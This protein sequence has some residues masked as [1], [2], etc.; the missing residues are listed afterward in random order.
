MFKFS[1][2][3]SRGQW[4][5]AIAI[6]FPLLLVSVFGLQVVKSMQQAALYSA[7]GSNNSVLFMWLSALFSALTAGLYV[8]GVSFTARRLRDAGYSRS[9]II[10]Y[11]WLIVIF[12]FFAMFVY[13]FI[14]GF[15]PSKL[16]AEDKQEGQRQQA[17]A[18]V[19]AAAEQKRREEEAYR[20]GQAEAW[21]RE[22]ESR[23]YAAM[24]PMLSR[25]KNGQMKRQR[26][27][28][29]SS[30]VKKAACCL[31]IKSLLCRRLYLSGGAK[32]PVRAKKLW[33]FG[34]Q[35]DWPERQNER[36]CV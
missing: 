17:E 29:N 33:I 21:A 30:P 14:A 16:T 1:G 34:R 36:K 25:R 27:S 23:S 4:W 18:R 31:K 26:K 10:A 24:L 3:I 28:R 15:S 19:K 2:K 35:P 13:L 9:F 20:R 22:D 8:S 6:I 32:F 7:Y 12:S 5:V 11:Y